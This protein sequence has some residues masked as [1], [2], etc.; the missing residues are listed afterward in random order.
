MT[1]T[2]SPK[3][4]GVLGGM[5]PAAGAHFLAR[6]IE[7]TPAAC[8][9]EH[10]P[11]LL[12]NDP[13]IPDRTAAKLSGGKTPLPDMMQGIAMLEDAG[14]DCIAIPCNTAHLWFTQLVANSNV[15]ILHIV[16][17]VLDDLHLHGV[18]QGVVGILATPATLE[19]GLY[20]PLLEERGYEILIP[21]AEVL[22]DC[23]DAI[24]AVKGN[25]PDDAFPLAARAI[26]ALIA[27]GAHAVI[28]ACTELPLAIPNDR[29][30]EFDVVLTDSVDA[31]ARHVLA[32]FRPGSTHF[33]QAA[34]QTREGKLN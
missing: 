2:E 11:V 10:I 21:G 27:Q 26:N 16:D 8:D 4:L 12:R 19:L 7:M 32:L 9:Q 34:K 31:L 18:N 15:P 23:V 29:R 6:L 30:D 33:T 20:Q 17:A 3:V 5:G 13:R 22:Q 25:R 14:A 1:L 28:L 24:H